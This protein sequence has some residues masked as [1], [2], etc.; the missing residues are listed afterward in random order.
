LASGSA[1][2]T[3]QPLTAEE[4]LNAARLIRATQTAEGYF[5]DDREC[6]RI[7]DIAPGGEKY[8]ACFKTRQT[9]YPAVSSD[10]I[11]QLLAPLGVKTLNHFEHCGQVQWHRYHGRMECSVVG[12]DR[13][14]PVSVDLLLGYGAGQTTVGH[15]HWTRIKVAVIPSLGV[16]CPPRINLCAIGNP[17]LS[18]V[19]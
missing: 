19:K 8:Y 5:H 10:D 6:P 15:D 9:Y 13:G 12:S 14:I 17:L 4:V 2:P 11:S 1:D 18:N 16:Y 3:S 7:G